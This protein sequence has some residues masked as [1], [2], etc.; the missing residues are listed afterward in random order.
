MSDNKKHIPVVSIVKKGEIAI[1]TICNDYRM[2]GNGDIQSAPIATAFAIGNV[3][4]YRKKTVP[5][6]VV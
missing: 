3:Y 4:E 1:A 6:F 5:F 2:R